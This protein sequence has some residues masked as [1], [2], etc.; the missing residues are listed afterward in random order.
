[1]AVDAV[2]WCEQFT[3]PRIA[4]PGRRGTIPETIKPG[5]VCDDGSIMLFNGTTM[6]AGAIW[7][8]ERDAAIARYYGWA[9]RTNSLLYVLVERDA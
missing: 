7:L 1:M 4:E 8:T 3:G 9:E 6:A 5:Q 2:G